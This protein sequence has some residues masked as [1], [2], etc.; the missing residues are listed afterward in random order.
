M[1]AVGRGLERYDRPTV[2][3][4]VAKLPAQ[5]YRFSTLISGIVNSLP[6]QMRSTT[7]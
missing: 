1:Y 3:E 7:P 2:S 5:D 4:I 6:F